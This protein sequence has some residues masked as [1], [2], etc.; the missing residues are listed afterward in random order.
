MPELQHDCS[1]S[2]R[3]PLLYSKMSEVWNS[4][5]KRITEKGRTMRGKKLRY[6]YGPVP[7]WRLGASLGIDPISGK[8][9]ICTFDCAY[10]QLGKTIKFTDE[11]RIYIPVDRIIDEISSLPPVKIDYITFSGRGEPTL[12]E[13]LGKMIKAIKTLR[14]EKI[15]VITNSSLMCKE[16][17]REDLLLADFVIAKLDAYSQQ[18]LEAIN[19]PI[20][21]IAF[22]MILEGIKQF[23]PEYKGKLAL[24]IMFINENKNNAR[25]LVR[26]AREIEPDEV[27]VNTPLRPC[28]VKPLSK[29]EISQIKEYFKG[30]NVISVYEGEKKKV[31]SISEKETLRRRGKI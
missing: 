28:G 7:S 26:L 6:I 5:D 16:D 12:A 9:K 1:T 14:R 20:N 21:G 22:D 10:C 18:S 19:K 11:R 25:E 30:I 13:N 24:Q 2:G 15:A 31:K 17:V 8:D 4:N 27:Q 29:E 3:S 23:R